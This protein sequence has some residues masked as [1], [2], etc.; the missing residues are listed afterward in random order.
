MGVD[1]LYSKLESATINSSGTF[2]ASSTATGTQ[3]MAIAGSAVVAGR[4]NSVENVDNIA[5]RFRV[6]KD[7]LP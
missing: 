3:G 6:H 4:P 5:V 2:S 1:V 7:F